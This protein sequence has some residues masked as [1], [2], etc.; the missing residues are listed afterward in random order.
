MAQTTEERFAALV[1][2]GVTAGRS[3]QQALFSLEPAH[4]RA[5]KELAAFLLGIFRSLETLDAGVLDAWRARCSAA[6]GRDVLELCRRT[7]EPA[8]M[9]PAF[10]A[11]LTAS[12]EPQPPP[13]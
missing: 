8:F 12:E 2:M 9:E 4:Q 6:L 10:L 11:F 5:A 7:G 1:S 13:H 3:L